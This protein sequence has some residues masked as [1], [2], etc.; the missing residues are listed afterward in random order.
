M[1]ATYGKC[2]TSSNNIMS[3]LEGT[4][5]EMILRLWTNPAG[6]AACLRSSHS[7]RWAGSRT[8]PPGARSRSCYRCRRAGGGGVRP[9]APPP[10]R[11]RWTWCCAGPAP[12]ASCPLWTRSLEGWCSA[13]RGAGRTGRRIRK[14]SVTRKKL[15]THA[16]TDTQTRDTL[17]EEKKFLNLIPYVYLLNLKQ[18]VLV[19]QNETMKFVTKN[20][21]F[22]NSL[23]NQD[24]WLNFQGGVTQSKSLHCCCQCE[25]SQL[26][27]PCPT[28]LWLLW[29]VLVWNH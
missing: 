19:L 22:W 25:Y 26:P 7:C 5:L 4:L 29:T 24:Q 15:H 11:C 10:W 16:Q 3:P 21:P 20:I 9:S 1:M 13:G 17:L 12:P 23:Q 8:S 18:S 6:A 27:L 14:I 28:W 2:T